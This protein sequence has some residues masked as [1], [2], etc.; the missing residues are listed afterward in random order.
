MT[1]IGTAFAILAAG[2]FT[3]AAWTT[4]DPAIRWMAA[5]LAASIAGWGFFRKEDQ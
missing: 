1:R 4:E 2:C 5:G 3:L